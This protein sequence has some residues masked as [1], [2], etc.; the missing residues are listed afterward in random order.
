MDEKSIVDILNSGSDALQGLTQDVKA[1]SGFLDLITQIDDQAETEARFYEEGQS[2]FQS[3]AKGKAIDELE[4]ILATFF[5]PPE[6][7]AGKPLPIALRFN[8]SAKFLGGIQKEQSLFI[9]K[10][11]V[12]EL[13]GALWPWQRKKNT[14]TIHLGFCSDQITDEDYGLLESAVKK[15]RVLSLSKKVADT[16]EGVVRGVSLTSFLQMAEMEASSCTLRVTSN[17]R[18]GLLYLLEGKLLDAKTEALRD[19]QAAYRI[20]SWQNAEI[21]ILPATEKTEDTI[22]QPLMH[23]LMESLK[24]KDEGTAAVTQALP[25]EDEITLEMESKPDRETEVP[26]LVKEAPSPKISQP[27][28][29]QPKDNTPPGLKPKKDKKEAV[30]AKAQSDKRIL[31]A[32]AVAVLVLVAAAGLVAVRSMQSSRVEKTYSQVLD[33]VSQTTDLDEK[34]SLLIDFIEAYDTNEYTLDAQAQLEE[35]STLIEERDYEVA[36]RR[37]NDL[38]V[39]YRYQASALTYLD[40]FKEQH[41]ESTRVSELEQ[42]IDEIVEMVD[43]M[44][45]EALTGISPSD[46]DARLKAYGDY[47]DHHP[48][49]K[50]RNQ[51]TGLIAGLSETAFKELKRKVKALEK[52][53]QYDQAIERCRRY[54]SLFVSSSRLADVQFLQAGLEAKKDLADLRVLAVR[55][56]SDYEAARA[57]FKDYLARNPQTSQRPNIEKEIA[58]LD[59]KIRSRGKWQKMV[60]YS[61][62]SNY[63]LSDRIQRLKRF[64]RQNPASPF[65]REAKDLLA[66]LED[67]AKI[68]AKRS[69]EKS[70]QQQA[71]AKVQKAEAQRQSENLRLQREAEKVRSQIKASQGRYVASGNQVVRDTQTGLMWTTLDSHL[72]LGRCLSYNSAAQYVHS[73]RNGG[74]ADW[75]MPTAA[76]LAG[77]YKN[78]PFFPGSG[79][80]WYWTSE[81]YVKGFNRI[82]NIVTTKKETVFKRAYFDLKQCGAARAV[83]P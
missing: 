41:P 21:E 82:A 10:T 37:I 47:L 63:P 65:I 57:L 78:S 42:M 6:K 66:E 26:S 27:T 3:I 9:K 34:E 54:Q 24:I 12:G 14:I 67:E 45:Y 59:Q 16:L 81:T 73:L 2:L 61:R 51:V 50:Y 13:Y 23:V 56:G 55:K 28:S 46:M 69:W 44:E 32:A 52:K 43:D 22:K 18:V 64:I 11:A 39:D 76:E 20:I 30:L 58:Q 48:D 83:R 40:A 31:W 62:S 72:E 29:A 33:Q 7:P 77:I 19:R 4:Q 60:A 74:Y 70:L 35:I 80:Q 36:S 68:A 17:G 49:G 5:G 25:D 75:R 15:A 1:I 38:P 79:A 53:R 8:N 71:Q